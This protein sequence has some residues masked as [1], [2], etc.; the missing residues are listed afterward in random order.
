[1]AGGGIDAQILHRLDKHLRQIRRILYRLLHPRHHF[2]DA[3]ALT[4]G[5]QGNLH[6]A[7]V[8]RRIHPV[9]ADKRSNIVYRRILHQL[10]HQI[11]LHFGHRRIRNTLRRLGHYLQRAGVLQ[12]KKAFG[13]RDIQ[14]GGQHHG[15]QRHQQGSRLVFQY[16]AQRTG[17]TLGHSIEKTARHV[18]KTA[19]L[20]GR[21]MF[22]Q[23]RAHHRRESERYHRRNQNRHR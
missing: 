8:E 6:P 15:G 7:A 13:H 2:A 20:F 10:F 5:L 3:V 21:Q 23:A 1:M 16:P 12:G 11:L 9:G 19:L 18:I 14:Q 4:L 22:Q 17:I